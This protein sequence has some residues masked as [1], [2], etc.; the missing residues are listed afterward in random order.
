MILLDTHIWLWLLHDPSRLSDAANRL[1]AAEEAQDG[2]LVSTISV[3][4]VAVKVSV[5]KLTL[6]LPIATW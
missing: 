6:P 1:I 3:W 4:E 5:G 2:L